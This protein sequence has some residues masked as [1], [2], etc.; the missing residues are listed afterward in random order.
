MSTVEVFSPPLAPQEPHIAGPV[1]DIREFGAVGNGVEKDT[2]AIQEAIDC[3]SREGGVVMVPSGVF[4]TDS[5]RLRSNVRLH[6]SK[7]AVLLG[8]DNPADYPEWESDL[9][10]SENAPYNAKY[11]IVAENE[12]NIAITGEGTINGQGT[13]HYDSSDSGATWWPVRDR[14]TRP[15]RMVMFAFC[16]NIRIEGITC[17]DSPAWTF[18]VLGCNTVAFDRVTIRT[19]SQAINTDGIDIDSSRNVSITHC[20][21]RTGDDAIV[22]RAI[23]RVMKKPMPCEHAIVENC[24]LTSRCQ[25]IR[26]GYIRDGIIRNITIRNITILDS[27]RGIICQVPSPGETPEKRHDLPKGAGPLIENICFE[28]IS[29]DANQP[30]WVYISDEGWARGISN[31]RFENLRIR[32]STASVLKGNSATPLENIMFS[33]IRITMI[34]GKPCHT[35]PL[36][37]RDQALVLACE[38][39]R[40]MSFCNVFI[41][42]GNT[43]RDTSMPAL[44]FARIEGL[45]L[46]TAINRSE[47]KLTDA[48]PDFPIQSIS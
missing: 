33:N 15:G 16:R 47:H 3:C 36:K 5:F 42:G 38:H 39:V 19:P 23:D 44:H 21:I 41:E 12:E 22:F 10:H 35:S 32:G 24:T 18:W 9:F 13:A 20:D 31:L 37:L 30:L 11:L 43:F 2:E 14:A 26:V 34:S 1:Y 4:L 29:I 7:G 48:V 8:S 25:A 40:N 28:N 46:R 45:D 17:V 6:L 27:V